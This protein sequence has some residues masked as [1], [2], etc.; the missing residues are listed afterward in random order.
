MVRDDHLIGTARESLRPLAVD[1]GPSYFLHNLFTF[2]SL[3][4]NLAF[5][6]VSQFPFVDNSA[7]EWNGGPRSIVTC[8][9]LS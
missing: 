3:T 6:C 4:L 1:K 7:M 2:L 8:F 5:L 9:V